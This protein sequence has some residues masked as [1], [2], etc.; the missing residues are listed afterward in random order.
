[1][2]DRSIVV[3]GGA[4]F[5]GSRLCTRLLAAGHRVTA[6]DNLD[7]YYEPWRKQ[8]NLLPLRRDPN[9]RFERAD[10]RDPEAMRR[11]MAG[12]DSVVHFAARAGVRPSFKQAVLYSDVN[13]TG[14]AVMLQSAVDAGVG[15]FVFASSSSVYGE[16]APTPFR[17]EG[18]L[19]EPA[20]PYAATKLAGEHL[21][22][23]FFPAIPNIAALR[24]FSVYGPGQ[25]PDLAIHTFAERITRGEPIPVFGTLDSFRDYTFVEDIVSG[26]VAA[27]GT[28]EPWL[29]VNL[30]SGKPLSLQEM[31][32]GLESELGRE[33]SKQMLPRADGDLFGTWA[34]I[35]RAESVLGYRPQWSFADGVRAFVRWFVEAPLTERDALAAKPL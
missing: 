22:R 33:A 30:G 3:S 31:I 1:M 29:V 17:E 4:G 25:R 10:V 15:R 19:G 34:D 11:V 32:E 8:A 2:P 18:V 26:F 16:G 23:S 5:I 9:F 6:V 14:T 20:S 27:L 21:C 7:D 35:S 12:A 28:D 13:V 24:L